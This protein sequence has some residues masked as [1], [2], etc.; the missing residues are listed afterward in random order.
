MNP[1]REPAAIAAD[2]LAAPELQILQRCCGCIGDVIGPFLLAAGGV[3]ALAGAMFADGTELALGSLVVM[4][5][6]RRAVNYDS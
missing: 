2:A 6:C 4:A 3:V 5:A 1:Y